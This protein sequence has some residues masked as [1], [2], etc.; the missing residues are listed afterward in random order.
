MMRPGKI[1]GRKR[2]P[3]VDTDGRTLAITVQVAFVQDR[4]GAAAAPQESGRR[5]PFIKNVFADA[6]YAGERS[7]Q[8]SRIVVEVVRKAPDQL[9]FAAPLRRWV[10][11]RLFGW[12][13]R[14]R[15]L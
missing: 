15:R 13:T 5:F 1:M 11:E 6:G 9:G 3:P 8:A 14:N 7:A 10:V 2:Q 4:D 12:I